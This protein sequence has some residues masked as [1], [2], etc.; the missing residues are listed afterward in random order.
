MSFVEFKNRVNLI[1]LFACRLNEEVFSND[2]KR[3]LVKVYANTLG[4][5]L[6][7]RMAD[8]VVKQSLT[9]AIV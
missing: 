9:A 4:I 8:S 2:I 7:D 6:S 5:N 3:I 1:I